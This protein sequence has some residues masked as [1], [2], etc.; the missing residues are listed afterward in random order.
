[1]QKDNLKAFLSTPSCFKAP[2]WPLFSGGFMTLGGT[3]PD[4]LQIQGSAAH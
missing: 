3:E 1:M 4:R 2:K